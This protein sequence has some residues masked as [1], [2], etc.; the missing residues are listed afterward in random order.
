[1]RAGTTI[2]VYMGV[3]AAARISRSLLD[4]GAAPETEVEIVQEAS[5]DRQRVVTTSIG[6]LATALAEAGIEGVATMIIRFPKTQRSAI[7]NAAR[8]VSVGR[9]T[10]AV[11][12]A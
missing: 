2:V 7:K 3:R 11:V 5:T 4:A 9:R 12:G 8:P 10:L 1:M 6:S